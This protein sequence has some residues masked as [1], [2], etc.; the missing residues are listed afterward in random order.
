MVTG[1]HLISAVLLCALSAG[2]LRA[3][4]V[5]TFTLVNGAERRYEILRFRVDAYILRELDGPRTVEILVRDIQ[6]IDYGP[7]PELRPSPPPPSAPP[8]APEPEPTGE[9]TYTKPL[10]AALEERDFVQLAVRAG[11]MVR[12]GDRAS[13]VAFDR[14]V[15]EELRRPELTPVP[16]R[17]LLLSAIVLARVLGEEQ[18][19]RSLTARAVRTYRNDPVFRRFLRDMKELGEKVRAFRRFGAALN[20]END[21]GGR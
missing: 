13:V 8:E 16:R 5:A 21:G 20:G 14:H 12:T 18:R 15:R 10:V 1:R 11:G 2:A 7:T 19:F 9:A 4:P 17:D 3:G 6:S